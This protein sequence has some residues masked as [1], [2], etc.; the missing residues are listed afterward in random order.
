M[1][2]VSEL[3]RV[4]EHE[5]TMVKYRWYLDLLRHIVSRDVTPHPAEVFLVHVIRR[6]ATEGRAFLPEKFYDV[7]LQIHEDD[8]S[9]ME[10][11]HTLAF[12]RKALFITLAE[13]EAFFRTHDL[14]EQIEVIKHWETKQEKKQT[15][16]AKVRAVLTLN[17]VVRRMGTPSKG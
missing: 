5:Q 12:V 17:Q 7:V 15:R 3:E 16:M 13:W 14:P 8:L 9:V 2:E 1:R 6:T 10:V 11:Q 4:C